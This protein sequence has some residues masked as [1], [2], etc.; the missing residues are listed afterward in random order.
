M[1]PRDA[2]KRIVLELNLK[3]RKKIKY[4]NEIIIKNINLVN[5]ISLF[6]RAAV[7]EL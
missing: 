1:K 2:R 6:K 4:K 7:V 3:Q 5:A